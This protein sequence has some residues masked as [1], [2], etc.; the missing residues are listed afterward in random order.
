MVDVFIKKPLYGTMVYVRE[1]YLDRARKMNVK[2]HI[3]SP[4]GEITCTADEWMKGAKY[5][6]KVFLRPE[7]PMRLWGKQLPVEVKG[8]PRLL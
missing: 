8:Q 5:M 4:N 6:E 3:Q 7:E 1:M 2:L